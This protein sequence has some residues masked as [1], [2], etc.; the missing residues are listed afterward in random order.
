[1]A[2]VSVSQALQIINV[3][4]SSNAVDAAE[5]SMFSVDPI[6]IRA[7]EA[8]GLD[9]P[10]TREDSPLVQNSRMVS[11]ESWRGEKYMGFFLR[12]SHSSAAQLFTA[13]PEIG[14]SPAMKF[15]NLTRFP[16]DESFWKPSLIS[17][18]RITPKDWLE[19]LSFVRVAD[20][21]SDKDENLFGNKIAD[22]VA[23]DALLRG[24]LIVSKIFD[25]SERDPKHPDGRLVLSG[26]LAGAVAAHRKGLG[27][28]QA[29]VDDKHSTAP[30]PV[31]HSPL[32]RR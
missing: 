30:S 10:T 25:A 27:W 23:I 28:V 5:V 12:E 11:V 26:N 2:Q 20:L 19:S 17:R 13:H 9:G 15:D 4:S 18:I 22:D 14:I 24:G 16:M 31:L 6:W 3:L 29:V 21:W 8:V 7:G 32:I 1:M